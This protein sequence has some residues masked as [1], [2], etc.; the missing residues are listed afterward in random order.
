MD[1]LRVTGLFSYPV[2]SCGVVAHEVLEMD[3]RGPLWDRRWMVVD[4]DGRFLTQREHPRLALVRPVIGEEGLVLDVSG[5]ALIGVPHD[6][7]RNAVVRVQVW[8]DEC[9]AWDEGDAAAA[10]LSVHL[11]TAVRL[12]RMTDEWARP[13]DPDYSPRPARTGFADAFPLLVASEASLAELNRR[14]AERDRPP[15]PMSRF[16]PNVVLAGAEPFAEDG[17]RTLVVGGVTLDL[18][19]PCAR[20]ATTTVDQA[21]GSV[22]DPT[23]PLATLAGFRRSGGK[24]LFGQNAVHRAPGRLEVGAAATP[25]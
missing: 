5:T 19:K 3:D 6:R 25:A 18:V 24:V 22:P 20:C 4:A 11:G 14:L 17:W 21:S 10:A 13:V 23:E 12:V 16:R 1:P 8:D 7:A 2:K 9:E 15:V